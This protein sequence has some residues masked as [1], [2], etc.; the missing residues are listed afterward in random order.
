[1]FAFFVYLSVRILV[2]EKTAG[3]PSAVSVCL[4]RNALIFYANSEDKSMRVYYYSDNLVQTHTQLSAAKPCPLQSM[5][6]HT[7]S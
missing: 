6:E 4:S 2:E 7:F 3:L 1:M 5:A